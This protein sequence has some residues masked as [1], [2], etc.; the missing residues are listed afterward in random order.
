LSTLVYV[1][2][3]ASSSIAYQKVQ[4]K[5]I[6]EKNQTILSADSSSTSIFLD[7]IEIEGRVEKP[8]TIFILPGQDPEVDSIQIERSF[9]REIFRKIEK[10]MLN[11]THKQKV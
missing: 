6:P 5:A 2:N 11:K 1:Q 7:K 4:Q 8:Q 3:S 9:F 10:D